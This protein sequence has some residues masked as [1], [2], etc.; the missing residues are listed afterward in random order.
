MTH[1]PAGQ[2]SPWDPRSE[3]LGEGRRAS[4]RVSGQEPRGKA[5]GH[6]VPEGQRQGRDGTKVLAPLRGPRPSCLGP[7]TSP[8]GHGAQTTPR[9]R[10]TPHPGE[11]SPGLTCS[12]TS[13]LDWS[14]CTSS[15][16][17]LSAPGEGSCGVREAWLPAPRPPPWASLTARCGWG[18]PPGVGPG[19]RDQVPPRLLPCW[20]LPPPRSGPCLPPGPRGGPGAHA[21]PPRGQGP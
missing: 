7:Q 15:L 11:P 14:L 13:T 19:P 17:S 10:P 2:G 1:R 18:G 12:S 20:V 21:C 9:L 8:A 5:S 16:T 6:S 3:G 4:E